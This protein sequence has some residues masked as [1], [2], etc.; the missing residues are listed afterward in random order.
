MEEVKK[1]DEIG[2]T[3]RTRRRK[4]GGKKEKIFETRKKRC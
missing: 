3:R 1:G 4:R 2:R